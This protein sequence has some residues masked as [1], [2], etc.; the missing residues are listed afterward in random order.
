VAILGGEGMGQRGL[1]MTGAAWLAALAALHG[2]AGRVMLALLD[3][4]ETPTGPCQAIAPWPEIMLRSPAAQDWRSAT[5]VCGCGGGM[6]VRPWLPQILDQA[7][8]LV[9]DADAL[10]AVAGD[11]SLSRTLGDR[12]RRGLD[13]VLTPHPLEAARLLRTDTPQVQAGRLHA[14]QELARRFD[15]TVLLKGS[16]SVIAGPR[17]GA[18]AGPCCWINPTGNAR[19]STGGTGDVLAGLVAALWAQGLAP[20]LAA[21]MGA[22]RHGAVAEQ[23]P[24]QRPFSASALARQLG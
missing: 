8:R 5:V 23:W 7:P 11:S 4:P 21:A 1:S 2:G 14:A 13:T 10:N 3:A 18:E 15:C 6:A 22:H 24:S 16:G 19:L 12:R 17:S 20:T 9:L